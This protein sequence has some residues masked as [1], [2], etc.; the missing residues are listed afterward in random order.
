MVK[1]GVRAMDAMTEFVA[2]KLP[3]LDAKLDYYTVAGASKRGWTTWDLGAVDPTRVRAIVPIVLDAINFV[4]VMHHQYMSYNGWSWALQ[5][6][7]EENIFT[8][9]DTPNMK[10]LAQNVDPYYYRNRLTMPK[11]VVNAALDEFQ[12]PDDTR[13]WWDEM[14]GPKHFIMTPNAEHSEA[15]G[16]F[17]IVPA[18]SAWVQK[19]LDKEPVPEFTWKIDDVTGEIVATL[20]VDTLVKEARVW[21]AYSC[22]NNPDGKKRRDFRIIN[23]DDPCKCG[24][25]AQGKCMDLKS[26]W[27]HK[28]LDEETVAGQK[29][30]RAKMDAP[31][32]GRWVAFFIDIVLA[33]D[34]KDAHRKWDMKMPDFIPHDLAQRVQFTTE[35]SVFPNTFPYPDCG[36][37]ANG[38]DTGNP[39]VETMR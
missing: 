23:L 20:P 39:C 8:Q 22:G 2:T 15:T 18:I 32:D 24:I 33:K 5:D 16:I 10:L 14:P 1:A 34:K 19:Q 26:F 38:K 7:L 13:Y 6:Y 21:W 36:I 11:L 35:V 9:L 28:K 4:P 31:D 3:E 25:R 29:T 30:F 27:S 37:D 17:E 12:Q